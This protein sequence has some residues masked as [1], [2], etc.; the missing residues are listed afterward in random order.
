MERTKRRHNTG[1]SYTGSGNKA[2][3]FNRK[4]RAV[5]SE[6]KNK[7]NTKSLKDHKLEFN[8]NKLS[9]SDRKIIK[10]KIR[11]KNKRKNIIIILISI[12]ILI[13]IL[14]ILKE[15]LEGALSSIKF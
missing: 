2:S 12:I 1:F 15:A 4:P 11:T 14:W 7:L 13:P 10:D 8:N 9:E 6:I 3:V 5:F